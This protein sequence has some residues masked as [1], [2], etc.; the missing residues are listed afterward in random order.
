ADGSADADGNA[1]SEA[2]SGVDADARDDTTAP[3][4]DYYVNASAAV[5]GD[6]SWS[7]PFKTI[8][9]AL[10]QVSLD[11]S[12]SSGA[13]RIVSIGAGHYDEALGEK[14]PLVIRGA[15]SLVGASADDTVIGG[16]GSYDHSRDG[17]PFNYAFTATM[18]VGDNSA[19]E[20]ISGMT[21]LSNAGFDEHS[22]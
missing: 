14:F 2:G 6:G 16:L 8:T 19:N 5:D 3:D 18:L 22:Y 17:G 9:T 4:A 21:I 13:A 11:Q 15:T 7:H 20:L 1:D 10:A 12:V